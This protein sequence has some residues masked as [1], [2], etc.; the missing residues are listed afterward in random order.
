MLYESTKLNPESEATTDLLF[1]PP[2]RLVARLANGTSESPARIFA[3]T[4]RLFSGC[5]N[6]HCDSYR[7][8]PLDFQCLQ[9]IWLFSSS[10]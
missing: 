4:P 10:L 6:L 3:L 1:L 7:H 5:R 8:H 9:T 2:L